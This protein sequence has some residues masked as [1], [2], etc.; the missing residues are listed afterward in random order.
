MS[1]LLR[2]LNIK[3]L[4]LD[5]LL[6]Y[7]GKSG[8]VIVGI[9]VLPLYQKIMGPSSFGVVALLLSIQAFL[10]MVDLGA[11][12][13]VGRNLAANSDRL[14]SARTM[15]AAQMNLHLFYILLLGSFIVLSLAGILSFSLVDGF[16][17]VVFFWAVTIQNVSQSALLAMRKYALA[18]GL[19]AAGILFRSIVTLVCLLYISS[20]VRTFL[21]LQAVTAVLHMLVT[22]RMCYWLLGGAQALTDK[23]EIVNSMRKVFKQGFPLILFGLSGAL[24]MQADKV[25]ISSYNT[26]SELSPYYLAT[27]LCL[28]PIS[29]LAAPVSQYFHPK[30]VRAVVSSDGYSLSR[31]VRVM[32]VALIAVVVVPSCILWVY[33]Q[34]IVKLWLLGQDNAGVVSRYVD[35]LLPGVAIGAFGFI[36]YSILVAKEDYKFQAFMSVVLTVLTLLATLYFSYVGYVAGVCY[37][38]ATYHVFSFLFSWLRFKSI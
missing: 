23:S 22:D 13:V 34:E 11:A 21:V 1:G 4:G 36:P 3:A 9:F 29:V 26:P 5:L 16:L 8:S 27:V 30:I 17:A 24:V 37:V 31:N 38:Y 14:I 10:L 12:T 32:G 6:L 15:F 19:Q 25:I 33:S 18:G 35:I 20:D 7:V 2:K 28:T